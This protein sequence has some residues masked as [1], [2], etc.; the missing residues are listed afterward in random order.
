MDG[1]A[2]RKNNRDIK[3]EYSYDR[4]MDMKIIQAYQ[5][6]VPDKFWVTNSENQTLNTIEE[7]PEHASG[8]DIR[9]SLFGSTKRR[10]HY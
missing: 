10:T 8:R 2:V 1:D 6:L 7:S 3:L 4:L 5:L 9:K